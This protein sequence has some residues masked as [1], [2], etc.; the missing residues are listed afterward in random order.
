MLLQMN[1]NSSVIKQTQKQT[2]IYIERMSSK[3]QLQD[4]VFCAA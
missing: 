3:I 2:K 4:W 1:S